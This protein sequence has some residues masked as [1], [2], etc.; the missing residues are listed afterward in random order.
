MEAVH[1]RRT[2]LAGFEEARA[3]FAGAI[4]A[5]P[6]EALGYLKPGDDYALGGL[7]FHVNAVL[8]HYRVVLDAIRDAGFQ[9]TTAIDPPGLMETAGARARDGLRPEERAGVLGAM[10]VQHGAV[11]RSLRAFDEA[12]WQRQAPVR[13]GAGEEP[14]PTSPA[15]VTGWLADHYREHVPHAEQLLADWRAAR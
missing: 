8:E 13:F 6:D 15:D 10:D 1:D 12:D 3:A 9:E 2:D 14:Y 4:A 5:V 7:L 11:V